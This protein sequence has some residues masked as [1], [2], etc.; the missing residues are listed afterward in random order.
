MIAYAGVT[1]I[2]LKT[3]DVNHRC[4]GQVLLPGLIDGHTH[5]LK[6]EQRNYKAYHSLVL[7]RRLLRRWKSNDCGKKGIEHFKGLISQLI[8]FYYTVAPVWFNFRRIYS[9]K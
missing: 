7:Q 1:K 5:V 8:L 2:R 9:N 6:I 3:I 4:R